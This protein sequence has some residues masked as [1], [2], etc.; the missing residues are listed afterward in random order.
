MLHVL[1]KQIFRPV[2]AGLYLVGL[3]KKLY[4]EQ[5]QWANYPTHVNKTGARHFDLLT[6]T[7]IVREAL[8]EDV[9]QFFSQ[10]QEL[11]KVEDWK[12]KTEPFWLYE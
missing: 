2:Y 3:L 7:P 6:G 11:T 1:D 4:P 9:I 12:Q 10:I 8:E 5:L